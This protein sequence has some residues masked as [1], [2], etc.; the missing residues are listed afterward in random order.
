[1][2]KEDVAHLHNGILLCRILKFAGKWMEL[3]ETILNEVTQSQK[4]ETWYVLT[5]IWN[6]DIEQ[7]ITSL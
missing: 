4:K 6:L 7:R 1:M 2:D 3:E 5:H